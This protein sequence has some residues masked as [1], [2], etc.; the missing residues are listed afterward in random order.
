MRELTER[1][2]FVLCRSLGRLLRSAR[3]STARIGDH[4]GKTHVRKSR[5]FYAPLL[6]WMSGPLMRLLDS[7]VAVLS[8]RE[9]EERERRIYRSLYAASIRVAEKIGERLER[10]DSMNGSDVLVYGVRRQRS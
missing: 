8:Q 2:Y 9:W 5:V 6:V 1:A 7:G 4:G 10:T 3:Y